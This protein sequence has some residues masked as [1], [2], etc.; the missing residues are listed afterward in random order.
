MNKALSASLEAA[1]LT[2]LVGCSLIIAIIT[3]LMKYGA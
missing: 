1:A 3:L 2:A